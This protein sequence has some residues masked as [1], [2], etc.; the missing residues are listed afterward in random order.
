MNISRGRHHLRVFIHILEIGRH[1]PQF[2]L[3][4]VNGRS[5]YRY[6]S[7]QTQISG[8][9]LHQQQV[10]KAKVLDCR[11]FCNRSQIRNK[12]NIPKSVVYQGSIDS[13]DFCLN[14]NID[15][16][17]DSLKIGRRNKTRN[18]D[19]T[20]S[21]LRIRSYRARESFVNHAES[22]IILGIS[23]RVDKR[24]DGG[25]ENSFP[26]NTGLRLNKIILHVMCHINPAQRSLRGDWAANPLQFPMQAQG[27][28][29]TLLRGL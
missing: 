16:L 15:Y 27:P 11:F 24:V 28:N 1:L 7:I 23:H 10:P 21:I 2:T 8:Q 6:L 19:A 3:S 18:H 14:L 29:S 22:G 13:P 5:Y 20:V 26:Q 12:G 4:F 17:V 25:R 9:V